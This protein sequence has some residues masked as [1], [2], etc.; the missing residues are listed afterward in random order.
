MAKDP[1]VPIKQRLLDAANRQQVENIYKKA[2]GM[3]VRQAAERHQ[4]ASGGADGTAEAVVE[5][6]VELAKPPK[7]KSKRPA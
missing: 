5:S 1:A 3:A 7:G 6:V 2:G 4:D